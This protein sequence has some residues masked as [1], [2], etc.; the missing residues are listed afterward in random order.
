MNTSQIKKYKPGPA[1]EDY[2]Q[3]DRNIQYSVDHWNNF[4]LSQDVPPPKA[5][6]PNLVKAMMYVESKCGY[7]RPK[8]RYSGWPDVMQVANPANGTIYVLRNV[9]NPNKPNDDNTENEIV[10]GKPVPLS[11]P[12]AGADHPEDSIHWGVRWLYHKAQTN[13]E[14]KDKTYKRKWKTWKDAVAVYNSEKIN[15]LYAEEV[16]GIYQ[17][18]ADRGHRVWSVLLFAFL[19]GLGSIIGL[20]K[21]DEIMAAVT[22]AIPVNN[23]QIVTLAWYPYP[24][25]NCSYDNVE[26]CSYTIGSNS[27]NMWTVI[28]KNGRYDF[29]GSLQN[30]NYKKDGPLSVSLK[31]SVNEELNSQGDQ[32]KVVILDITDGITH[33]SNMIVIS[34][35]S[36]N[37]HQQIANYVFDDGDT[38]DKVRID[39]NIITVGAMI[40]GQYEIQRF[41]L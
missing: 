21:K 40:G 39:K 9:R 10:N 30:Y 8:D 22:R 38:V 25:L 6:D 24:G 3:Y 18:G 15:K 37:L 14:K 17:K 20:N 1:G 36:F 34:Q 19:I 23:P 28:L 35:E 29:P 26:D 27:S 41:K 12:E 31:E 5:L 16:F 2:N 4:F 32:N 11:Y 7:Y 13:I 33:W